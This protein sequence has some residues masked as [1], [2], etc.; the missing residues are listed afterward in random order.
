M[1]F[2][3]VVSICLFR[4]CL[5]GTQGHEPQQ[6]L[7]VTSRLN[8]GNCSFRNI[9]KICKKI[10][11]CHINKYPK[12]QTRQRCHDTEKGERDQD[13]YLNLPSSCEGWGQEQSRDV[14]THDI[15]GEPPR[16]SA[17]DL[18]KYSVL[19]TFDFT[20]Q[21]CPYFALIKTVEGEW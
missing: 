18:G 5:A 21:I 9:R 10:G 20:T 1:S 15:C 3:Y 7:Y 8:T 11:G 6:W 2:S 4:T 12:L 16:R 13:Y 17:S 14:S 19:N